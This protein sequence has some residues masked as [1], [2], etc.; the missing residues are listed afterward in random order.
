M[1]SYPLPE[2]VLEALGD[3]ITIG[4][5]DVVLGARQDLAEFR[6]L[7]PAAAARASG[8]G[9]ANFIHD[10]MWARAKAVFDDVEGV[11]FVEV[12]PTHDICISIDGDYYRLRLKRHTATGAI[13]SYPTPSAKD[14]ITQDG[15]DLF[16][17]MEITTL[18]LAVGYEWDADT[19][20]MRGP[21]MS[22]HDGSFDNAIWMVDL[23]SSGN[24]AGGTVEP[25]APPTVD[26]PSTP[27]I[28]IAA[29]E[30]SSSD[31]G[32]GTS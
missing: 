16:R 26:G 5:G 28:N 27:S 17:L 3:K 30:A 15:P 22:L 19:L 4:L 24:I 31:Q 25:I 9:L 29:D 7:M 32:T 20:D 8:R 14:F 11:T 1:K 12:E 23:P 21:V 18:N 6:T 13:R 2:D 10:A